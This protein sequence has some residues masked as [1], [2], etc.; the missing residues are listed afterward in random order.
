MPEPPAPPPVPEA[1]PGPRGR[2]SFG[3]ERPLPDFAAER[4]E[5]RARMEAYET[6]QRV[7]PRLEPA[8][9]P[10]HLDPSARRSTEMFY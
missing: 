1:E 4:R 7:D 5:R 10:D 8:P 6:A 9:A 3:F 2:W